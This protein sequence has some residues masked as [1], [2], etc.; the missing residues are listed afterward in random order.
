ML[1]EIET[2]TGE[3][4]TERV[5]MA[6]GQPITSREQ[7][8]ERTQQE[9]KLQN[10]VVIAPRKAAVILTEQVIITP[11][12]YSPDRPVI[13]NKLPEALVQGDWPAVKYASCISSER[14]VSC[15]GN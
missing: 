7:S 8:P 11:G 4:T 15:L 6:L 10:N 12:T 2:L 13:L 3:Y 5:E 14:R 1:S 9:R